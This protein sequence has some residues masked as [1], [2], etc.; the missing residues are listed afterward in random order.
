MDD[1]QPPVTANGSTDAPSP[2]T[3][4]A[5][6]RFLNWPRWRTWG[7][8]LYVGTLV[9]LVFAVTVVWLSPY[10]P[11]GRSIPWMV[12]QSAAL[13]AVLMTWLWLV[14]A[15]NIS[16]GEV[17]IFAGALTLVMISAASSVRRIDLTGDIFP[18]FEFRWEP[19]REERVRQH[20]AAT[21]AQAAKL[22]PSDI[23]IAAEPEDAPAYRG[24]GRDGT[25]IGP[26]LREDWNEK[27]PRPVWE[28]E[29]GEGYSAF[30]CVGNFL[31]T[32]EQRGPQ[33]ALVCYDVATG[34]QLWADEWASRFDEA[35]GGPGPRSTPTIDGKLVYAFGA[36]GDLL[37]REL[38]T[39]KEVWQTNVLKKYELKNTTWAMAS[40]P[41]VNAQQVI[42]DAGGGDPAAGPLL[43]AFDK[44]T[45]EL[46][47][48]SSG[49]KAMVDVASGAGS[50]D[51]AAEGENGAGYASPVLVKLAGVEQILILDGFGVRGV[52]PTNGQQFWFH[53]FRNGP[54][55][56]VAQPI[57]LEGDRVLVSASYDIGS[58]MLQISRD[59]DENWAV[60]S[61]WKKKSLRSKFSSPIVCDGLIYGVD[62]GIMV[63]LDPHDGTRLW[64]GGRCGHGQ[65]I[66]TNDQILVL[67][68][69]GDAVLVR[70]NPQK[71]DE[72]C[73]FPAL[74]G[75]KNWN[76]P[77]LVRGRLFVR[78]HLRKAAYDLK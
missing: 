39:G 13:L 65:L 42:V 70:P 47:W 28:G 44:L 2:A 71:Y 8:G 61:L 7:N 76:P 38:A 43:I 51:K 59:E 12:T 14:F 29:I 74:A 40:S 25:V 69:S 62:E 5:P 52:D 21:A 15:A 78:N 48:K 49:V 68:E 64:K 37:C 33:E 35:M 16:W 3:P 55:I 56:N 1:T 23:P 27:P 36:N 66:L 32:L 9:F 34:L 22:T 24:I 17:S 31:V 54:L 26:K 53:P 30:A 67:T 77:T 18:V 41:L 20:L 46:A 4:H 75:D 63:C 50:H 58:E 73:R 72:I 6:K 57:V 60:K 10:Q 11:V 45:G 19:T